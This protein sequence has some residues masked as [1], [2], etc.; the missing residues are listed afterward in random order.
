M[1]G[2]ARCYPQKER[3]GMQARA[4]TKFLVLSRNIPFPPAIQ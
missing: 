2:F 1:E 4:E 3:R